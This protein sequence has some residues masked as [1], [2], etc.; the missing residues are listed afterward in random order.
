[1]EPRT[2]RSGWLLPLF[3]RYP[4]H[5]SFIFHLPE[6][7]IQLQVAT[8]ICRFLHPI[9]STLFHPS[10]HHA[11]SPTSTKSLILSNNQI[12]LQSNTL[13]KIS[14]LMCTMTHLGSAWDGIG[15]AKLPPFASNVRFTFE[16]SKRAW[17]QIMQ[18]GF[19]LRKRHWHA[20]PPTT[21]LSNCWSNLAI[22]PSKFW[23]Q[24]S[25]FDPR[26]NNRDFYLI[27]SPNYSISVL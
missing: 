13:I 9:P 10:E 5:P 19:I 7:K 16:K 17:S 26:T 23:T 12:K 4:M 27:T 14:K 22:Y 8:P 18:G 25:L 6:T 3:K 2:D 21:V 1:M 11:R 24:L 20:T 15:A